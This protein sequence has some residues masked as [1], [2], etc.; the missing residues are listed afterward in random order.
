MFRIVRSDFFLTCASVVLGPFLIVWLVL[1][2]AYLFHP[3]FMDPGEPMIVVT[4]QQLIHGRPV[5]HAY[6]SPN[7]YSILYGPLIYELTAGGLKFISDPILAGKIAIAPICLLLWGTM[8]WIISRMGDFRVVLATLGLIAF[9]LL[10][11]AVPI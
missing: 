6:N 3:G 11:Y 2:T 10:W 5:Y 7:L 9:E 4:A 8:A 1:M